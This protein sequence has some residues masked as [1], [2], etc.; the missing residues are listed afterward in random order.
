MM[1]N[2][3]TFT[4]VNKQVQEFMT[5]AAH[6][7]VPTSKIFNKAEVKAT[8]E[9]SENAA[10]ALE[11]ALQDASEAP[12]FNHRSNDLMNDTTISKLQDLEAAKS[13]A[14]SHGIELTEEA[15]TKGID[16]NV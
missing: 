2:N 16:A 10:K 8:T 13:Y 12:F 15:T 5:E 9:A 3:V 1:I 11:K 6:K 14:K 7:Y 4:G